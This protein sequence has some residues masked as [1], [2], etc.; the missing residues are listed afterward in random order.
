MQGRVDPS[1]EGRFRAPLLPQPEH[2][3]TEH[4]VRDP[5]ALDE[6]A[7]DLHP[8]R[9]VALA[10]GEERALLQLAVG[11]GLEDLR[12]GRDRL[13]IAGLSEGEERH[14]LDL[15]I[16]V[17]PHHVEH[18]RRHGLVV[19]RL[20]AQDEH[21]LAA[22]RCA[23]SV[24]PRHH[25]LQDRYRALAVHRHQ[26]LHRHHL[27]VILGL[28]AAGRGGLV[29][30]TVPTGVGPGDRRT[31]R[32][33][34]VTGRP[35]TRRRR[36]RRRARG[37]STAGG[38][39]GCGIGDHRFVGGRLGDRP[40]RIEPRLR[41]GITHAGEV[42]FDPDPKRTGIT[43]GGRPREIQLLRPQALTRHSEIGG[44]AEAVERERLPVE[45]VA[46]SAR[47]G[48]AP[49]QLTVGVD[50][51]LVVAAIEGGLPRTMQGIGRRPLLGIGD[52]ASGL[53]LRASGEVEMTVG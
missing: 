44:P 46:R 34:P 27:L 31:G 20:L 24:P 21:R 42:P 7:Q 52:R 16:G 33:G 40:L 38:G 43:L 49:P 32:A 23:A 18:H 51:L 17:V 22:E 45:P 9:V 28:I 2:R 14:L 3:L 29:L 39:G 25:L 1:Q 50:R 30:P 35:G 8:A 37:G 10:Q 4:V 11:T 36:R 26:R 47:T 19:P 15:V 48:E 41:F 13:G 53:R 6:V 12:Q 5:G